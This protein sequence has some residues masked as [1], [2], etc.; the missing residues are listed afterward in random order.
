M[1]HLPM[2]LIYHKIILIIVL[3]NHLYFGN[4]WTEDVDWEIDP[5]SN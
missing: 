4:I 5:S 1:V 2:I 3:M